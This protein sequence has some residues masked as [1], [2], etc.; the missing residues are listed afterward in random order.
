MVMTLKLHLNYRTHS[1]EKIRLVS[2]VRW[3]V[4]FSFAAQ[5]LCVFVS[6]QGCMLSALCIS[7]QCC[8]L[9]KICP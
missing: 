9:V 6:N 7:Q 3:F 2:S 8:K 4:Y 1:L 5:A